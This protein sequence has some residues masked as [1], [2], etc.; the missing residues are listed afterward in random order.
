VR[1]HTGPCP[2]V[3]P[4]GCGFAAGTERPNAR[5]G[6]HVAAVGD[7]LQHANSLGIHAPE[8]TDKY[9]VILRRPFE[10]YFT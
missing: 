5:S 2:L 8:K 10:P 4:E 6:T 7:S 3:Q 9:A 1:L